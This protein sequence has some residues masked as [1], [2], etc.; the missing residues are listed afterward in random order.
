MSWFYLAH[1]LRGA[2]FENLRLS[3]DK[4]QRRSFLAFPLLALPIYL[5]DRIVRY[6][7]TD[8]YQTLDERNIDIVRAMN[9]FDLLFGRTVIVTAT[10]PR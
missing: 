5:G 8:R 3:V 9:S 4:Y 10:K 6:R 7:E 1:A 2:G